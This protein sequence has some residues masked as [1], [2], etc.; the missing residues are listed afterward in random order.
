[1][2]ATAEREFGDYVV[3]RTQA[4]CRFAF[5]LC[6][7]WHRAEDAVQAAFTKLYLHW[8]RL[9]GNGGMDAYVRKTVLTSIID[10]GRRGWFRREAVS[11]GLPDRVEVTDPAGASTDRLA[12]LA[13]LAKVPPRQRAV[14]V[15]RYWE[16]MSVEQVALALGCSAGT[17]KSQSARGLERLRLV[18]G[19]PM[20]HAEE[21]V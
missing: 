2:D 12:V 6:G 3:A 15:L 7:D 10:E 4:L 18:L 11:P 19:D 16:D 9:A 5:L 21:A 17:V 8:E 20:A 14:L 13:A 1:L